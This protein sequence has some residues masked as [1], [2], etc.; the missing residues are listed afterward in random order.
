[1]LNQ[2]YFYTWP[3]CIVYPYGTAYKLFLYVLSFLADSFVI[4]PHLYIPCQLFLYAFLKFFYFFCF[5]FLSR[6]FPFP[7]Y[8]Y[9]VSFLY[10][11][12]TS[13]IAIPIGI[14]IK[15]GL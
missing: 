9:N 15:L 5:L 10:K 13:L 1:M 2:R 7:H 12:G 3:A 11:K 6:F 14:F 8:I 4:L